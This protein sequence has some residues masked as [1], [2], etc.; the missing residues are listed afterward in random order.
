MLL[1]RIRKDLCIDFL[2]I[3]NNETGDMSTAMLHQNPIQRISYYDAS[4]LLPLGQYHHINDA[5]TGLNYAS[6][7]TRYG[8]SI[9]NTNSILGYEPDPFHPKPREVSMNVSHPLALSLTQLL[10]NS[11]SNNSNK[12][13]LNHVIYQPSSDM[14]MH[15]I[16]IQ[17]GY[18]L[19]YHRMQ[20]YNDDA[21]IQS[22]HFVTCGQEL[23]S[24][25]MSSSTTSTN[26]KEDRDGSFA[27][28][29]SQ[30]DGLLLEPPTLCYKDGIVQIQFPEGW[31][32][33]TDVD[34]TFD[35]M[36]DIY[37]LPTR[38]LKSP[39][40][41]SLYKEMIEIQYLVYE[42]SM[43]HSK[44]ASIVIQPIVHLRLMS[45]LSSSSFLNQHHPHEPYSSSDN[46]HNPNNH[47]DHQ[48]NTETIQL[49]DPLW[50]LA[51]IEIGQ[52]RNVPIIYD[53]TYT[54][55]YWMGP[56]LS[57]GRHILRKDP[58][59]I[60]YHFNAVNAIVTRHE[61]DTK[62]ETITVHPPPDNSSSIIADQLSDDDDDGSS[63]DDRVL[64]VSNDFVPSPLWCMNM[65]QA[66]DTN[67]SYN[68]HVIQSRST[69]N[70]QQQQSNKTSRSTRREKETKTT[71]MVMTLFDEEQVRSLSR[72][73]IVQQ[74]FTLGSILSV[75]IGLDD[76]NYHDDSTASDIHYDNIART[77]QICHQLQQDYG[78]LSRQMNNVILILV[79][80]LTSPQRCR[81]MLDA[82][83]DVVEACCN[84]PSSSS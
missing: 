43:V 13:T 33:P 51:L 42:H 60:L 63:R 54:N 39:K 23:S 45:S 81:T 35:Q 30:N 5:T 4:M 50:Q 44:I 75:T 78:I 36:N 76:E 8:S 21:T 47:V 53:E 77:S 17:H 25:T 80:P 32:I 70:G 29:Q 68:T 20:Q 16:A 62:M 19:F 1:D 49:I 64:V 56:S 31:N 82:V 22:C 66:I 26:T 71:T 34:S 41:K 55:S 14:N 18:D 67:L 28:T 73:S 52:S 79:S 10:L 27:S 59:M 74:S 11:S 72:L 57:I 12:S 6:T 84:V 40:L 2:S 83:H 15:H 65:I 3:S 58:D 48:F 61:D 24:S 9:I 7:L 38:I 46:S 37:D 69:N